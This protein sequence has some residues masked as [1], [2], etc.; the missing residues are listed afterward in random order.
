MESYK[1][2][3]HLHEANYPYI[4]IQNIALIISAKWTFYA[5]MEQRINE[6]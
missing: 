5:G 4:Q 3:P 1:G 6:I 2:C